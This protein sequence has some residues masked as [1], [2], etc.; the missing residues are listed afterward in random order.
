VRVIDR[1]DQGR[2]N[3]SRPRLLLVVL[4][5]IAAS[6]ALMYLHVGLVPDVLIPVLVGAAVVVG[7]PW[8]FL[9][10]WG[11]FLLVLVLWQQTGPVAQWAGFPAHMT[12][13][14]DADRWLTWPLL[15][16]QLP[17]EWLQQRLF[18]PAALHRTAYHPAGVWHGQMIN[19]PW[20]SYARSVPQWQWYDILSA[21]IYGLHFPEPLLVGFVIWVRDRALFRRFA[22]A[23]LALAALAFVIYIVYPAV[24]PW[25]ASYR[26]FQGHRFAAISPPLHKIFNDFNDYVQQKAFG[27]RYFSLFNVKYNLTAAMPSLHAAFPVLSALYLYKM[28]GRWGL[29][30]LVYAAAMWFAV[31][32]MGEHWI[33]D[34][35]VGLVCAVISFV[36]VE[37]AARWWGARA[38]AHSG[39]PA[40]VAPPVMPVEQRRVSDQGAR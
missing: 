9:R 40:L 33:I 8:L 12:D 37:G 27:H 2:F 13:L 10:D 20:F 28:F 16:G 39:V 30:M 15:H 31:V 17:Q 36:A 14:I 34:V 23:F 35:V 32:Y 19:R 18:H 22:A 11:V 29:L 21:V 7:R 1:R 3:I 4:Y 38:E 5:F 26:T 24:P 25:M 6:A